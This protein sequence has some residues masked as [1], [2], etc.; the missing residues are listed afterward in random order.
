MQGVSLYTNSNWH[1]WACGTFWYSHL[2]YTRNG[3]DNWETHTHAS[4]LNM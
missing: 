1:C 4:S 2:H 3:D